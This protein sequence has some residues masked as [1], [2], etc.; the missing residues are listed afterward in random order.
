MVLATVFWRNTLRGGEARRTCQWALRLLI[1]CWCLCALP[2]T[3]R[4]QAQPRN[5][6]QWAPKPSWVADIAADYTAP[7]DRDAM[8]DGTYT[9]LLDTRVRLAKNGVERYS[10]HVDLAVNQAGVATL[11]EVQ[12]EFSA[13]YQRLLLHRAAVIRDGRVID[14][15]KVAS[16]RML[17]QER[18]S[19]DRVYS[20][21]TTALLVLNDVRPGDAVDVSY[22]LSGANPILGGRYAGHVR[23][24][25]EA[26]ARRV[27]VQI[28]SAAERAELHWR[29]RGAA[30]PP[31]E[32]PIDGQRALTWDLQ[33]VQPPPQEDRVPSDFTAPAELALSEFADWSEVAKWASALYPPAPHFALTSKANELRAAAPDLD[34]A[35]LRALRFVQDDVRYLSI[36]LG[37]HS[38]KPHAPRAIYEQRFGDC[39]DKSYLLVELLRALGVEAHVA[40]ADSDLEGHLRE[41]LPSPFAFDHAIAVIELNGKRHYVDATWSFQGGTLAT[42]APLDLGVVLVVDPATNGLSEIPVPA[43]VGP[44]VT[45]ESEYEVA[46][47]GSATLNITTTYRGERADAERSRLASRSESDFSHEFL[48]FYE[49]AFP[50]VALG[51]ALQIKDDRDADVF[52]VIESYSIPEFWRNDERNLVPD[53]IWDYL[54]APRAQRRETPLYLSNRVWIREVQ[55]FTLPFNPEREPGER[56]FDDP[57]ARVTRSVTYDGRVVTASHEYRSFA[58]AV[59]LSGLAHHLQILSDARKEVGI[60]LAKREPNAEPRAA[61]A[62]VAGSAAMNWWPITLPVVGAFALGVA[63]LSSSGRRARKRRFKRLKQGTRGDLPQNPRVVNSL[64]DALADFTQEACSCGAGLPRDLVEITELSFQARALHAVR[65]ECPACGTLRRAYF[66]LPEAEETEEA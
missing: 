31:R 8:R 51:K 46:G 53:L 25:S 6:A 42:L 27:H 30:P 64:S 65:A 66:E 11:G 4:A 44:T 58:E 50:G 14:Q 18:D 47:S 24:G 20:G 34:T 39:K 15:T 57:A 45:A 60:E 55:R 2:L 36:S 49:K 54:V 33:D 48:N 12:I 3:A 63:L 13:H 17:E 59:P 1:S 9:L 40:L 32:I 10:R 61:D 43:L 7:A 62:I 23:L 35:V 28:T 56:T 22:T 5:A 29:V 19:A 26:P 37:P 38:V 21:T 41:S 16:L 52:T